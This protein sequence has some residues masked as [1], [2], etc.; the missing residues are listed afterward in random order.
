MPCELQIVK[1]CIWLYPGNNSSLCTSFSVK[2]NKVH[3]TQ[4]PQNTTCITTLWKVYFE[5]RN[6]QKLLSETGMFMQKGRQRRS[7]CCVEITMKFHWTSLS[8]KLG[9]ISSVRE[10]TEMTNLT[11]SLQSDLLSVISLNFKWHEVMFCFMVSFPGTADMRW[12][13]LQWKGLEGNSR[14]S[15]K[16][17]KRQ[18]GTKND[19]NV[20]N[21]R[22]QQFFIPITFRWQVNSIE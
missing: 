22:K 3:L 8:Y 6:L 10:S 9:E 20:W 12:H 16:N 4:S 15:K 5:L 19:F 18:H 7:S 17:E 14:T 13:F 1:K 2:P 11:F 21:D